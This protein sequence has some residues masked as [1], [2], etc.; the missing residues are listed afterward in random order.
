MTSA[1]TVE[2]TI[3]KDGKQVGR[4]R[5]NVMCQTC[6]DGLE[7]FQPYEDYTIQSWGYDEEEEEWENEP[8]NLKEWLIKNPASITFK[9]FNEGDIINVRKIG[10]VEVIK[11]FGIG[12]RRK[13]DKMNWFPVYTVKLPSGDVI[14]INQNDIKPVKLI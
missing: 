13:I 4:H 2:Y 1:N 12:E 6:N 5:Q 7:Q 10:E 3:L 8:E 11:R 14:D 9:D